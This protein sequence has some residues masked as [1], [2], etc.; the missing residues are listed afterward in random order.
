VKTADTTLILI[1]SLLLGIAFGRELWTHFAESINAVPEPTVPKF[2]VAAVGI[3]ALVFA[4]VVAA[5]PRSLAAR[6]PA[7]AVQR[8]E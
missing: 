1:Y 3:G 2:W 6:T 8:V 7:G 5:I 4:N